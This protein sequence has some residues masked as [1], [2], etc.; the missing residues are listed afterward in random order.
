MLKVKLAADI[1]IAAGWLTVC[2]L[3]IKLMNTGLVVVSTLSCILFIC[4]VWYDLIRLDSILPKYV[5]TF[6]HG[7]YFDGRENLTC[8]SK[9]KTYRNHRA[10]VR[11]L[12]KAIVTQTQT[13]MALP[14]VEIVTD[15]GRVVIGAFID[16]DEDKK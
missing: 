4:L 13:K 10:L 1:L 15:R 5:I 6:G 8:F 14:L 11:G 7:D 12:K 16:G 9:A 2:A 3:A